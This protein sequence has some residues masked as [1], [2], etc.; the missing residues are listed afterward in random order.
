[1]IAEPPVIAGAVKATLAEALPPVAAPIVGAPGAVA[2][3]V[4]VKVCGALVS[5]PPLAVPPLSCTVTVTVAVPL[6]DGFGVKVSV[7]FAAMAGCAVKSALFVTEAA[8]LTVCHTSRA[9]PG[10]ILVAKLAVVL[11]PEF[12]GTLIP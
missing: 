7:P 4:I 2:S 10:E 11:A 3:M 9:G 5:T 1:M 6:A 8:K 12:A